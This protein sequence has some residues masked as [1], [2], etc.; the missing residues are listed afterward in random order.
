[1]ARLLKDIISSALAD[2]PTELFIFRINGSMYHVNYA[3]VLSY[4]DQTPGCTLKDDHNIDLDGDVTINESGE[5]YDLIHLN[6]DCAIASIIESQGLDYADVQ[7]IEIENVPSL[8]DSTI[9]HIY[10]K[11][12]PLFGSK[13][14]SLFWPFITRI[15]AKFVRALFMHFFTDDPT[16]MNAGTLMNSFSSLKSLSLDSPT[17][18]LIFNPRIF[19]YLSLLCPVLETLYLNGVQLKGPVH[20][21]IQSGL[22]LT[23]AS[24]LVSNI[25]LSELVSNS[26]LVS[27]TVNTT[28]EQD[29][30]YRYHTRQFNSSYLEYFKSTSNVSFDGDTF[31]NMNRLRIVDLRSPNSVNYCAFDE[32]EL[33]NSMRSGLI[34]PIF[35]NCQSLETVIFPTKSEKAPN[36]SV[37]DL[38]GYEKTRYVYFFYKCPDLK[39]VV[40]P[41]YIKTTEPLPIFEYL[42]DP[43]NRFSSIES[44]TVPGNLTSLGSDLSD[45]YFKAAEMG[46]RLDSLKEVII[47]RTHGS[48]LTVDE[49]RK[50]LERYVVDIDSVSV[51]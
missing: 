37:F 10:F 26:K 30:P 48:N 6:V 19:V 2:R 5:T 18:E 9:V 51:S 3:D 35:K 21:Q 7:T 42:F 45:D 20:K 1:M 11:D 47:D 44:I 8:D 50:S 27:V 4:M 13:T 31:Y 25:S 41:S 23:V 49:V 40:F 22:N 33:K 36:K 38:D 28:H 24:G 32:T 12:F 39:K 14:S 43:T 34:T 15:D 17:N 16:K 46:F 29:E